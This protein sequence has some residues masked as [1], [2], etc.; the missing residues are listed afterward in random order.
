MTEWTTDDVLEIVLGCEDIQSTEELEEWRSRFTSWLA[1]HDAE[2][3]QKYI[4]S[5]EM[6]VVRI[7]TPEELLP[8]VR[9]LIAIQVEQ[10]VNTPPMDAAYTD[11]ELIE[12]IKTGLP[13]GDADE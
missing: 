10:W 6:P 3:I 4:E 9:E 11:T 7:D 2:V 12:F 8:I 13:E 5:K 1:S